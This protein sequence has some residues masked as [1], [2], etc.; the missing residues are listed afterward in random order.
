MNEK[1]KKCDKANDFGIIPS[2]CLHY[3]NGRLSCYFDFDN[4][5]KCK[6]LNNED[7]DKFDAGITF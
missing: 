2:A 1:I 4:P 5:C 6:A 3:N 7:C